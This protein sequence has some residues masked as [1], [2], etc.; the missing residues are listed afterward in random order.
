MQGRKADCKLSMSAQLLPPLC[1]PF[2]R[3]PWPPLHTGN[4]STVYNI[5]CLGELSL[6]F[7]I[8]GV[9]CFSA[10][11]TAQC[12]APDAHQH[13]N[14]S[15]LR[16]KT[17]GVEEQLSAR[18]VCAARSSVVSASPKRS[19]APN[20]RKSLIRNKICWLEDLIVSFPMSA[21]LVP[22][23]CPPFHGTPWPPTHT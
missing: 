3:T 17:C 8:S 16:N 9:A 18:Y 21:L 19:M 4:K 15:F 23:S 6:C 10:L 11:S 13:T 7:S 1:P 22:P 2:H 14:K 12:S 20:E 5:W